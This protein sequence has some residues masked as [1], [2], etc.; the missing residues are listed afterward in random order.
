MGTSA[1]VLA[2]GKGRCWEYWGGTPAWVSL[3]ALFPEALLPFVPVTYTS[4]HTNT[5]AKE[6][7]T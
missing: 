1:A 6:N 2:P 3:G 7:P 4:K 5:K